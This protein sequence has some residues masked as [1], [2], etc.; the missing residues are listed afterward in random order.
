MN[1][2]LS[3]KD[4]WFNCYS[5][6]L[7]RLAESGE[8]SWPASEAPIIAARMRVAFNTGNFNHDSAAIK[9]TCK[10]LGIKFGRGRILAYL[11]GEPVVVAQ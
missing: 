4:I 1:P 2:T 5:K 11:S 9:A 8:Y 3:N 10:E 7:T 6:H